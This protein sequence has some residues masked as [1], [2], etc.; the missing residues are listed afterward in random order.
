M[1]PIQLLGLLINYCYT[2]KPLKLYENQKDIVLE[3]KEL[4]GKSIDAIKSKSTFSFR[5]SN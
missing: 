1:K 4:I 2:M 5:Y 3:S